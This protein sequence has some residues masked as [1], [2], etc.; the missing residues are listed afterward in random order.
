MNGRVQTVAVLTFVHHHFVS[1]M[2]HIRFKQKLA[3]LGSALGVLCHLLTLV[4]FPKKCSLSQQIKDLSTDTKKVP[5][6][7]MYSC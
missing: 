7:R 2:Y 4:Q 3:F 6:F 1:C 5:V